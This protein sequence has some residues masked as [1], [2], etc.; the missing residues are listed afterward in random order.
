M[1]MA[2]L[3]VLQGAYAI[4]V[5]FSASD[6]GVGVGGIHN[7]YDVNDDISVS[8]ESSASFSDA[9]IPAMPAPTTSAAGFTGASRV[10][11]A[12]W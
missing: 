5:H 4:D 3:L 8:G 1:L 2:C 11:M 12:R 7:S 9:S 10:S 6:G